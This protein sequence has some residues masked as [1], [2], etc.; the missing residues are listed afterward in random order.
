M[1]K[2]LLDYEDPDPLCFTYCAACYYYMGLYKDAEASA[3]QVWA[4]YMES[5]DYGVESRLC[6]V[7][8]HVCVVVAGTA[9]GLLVSGLGQPVKPRRGCISQRFGHMLPLFH[10]CCNNYRQHPSSM[11][12]PTDQQLGGN[13]VPQ[14][15]AASTCVLWPAWRLG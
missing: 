10:G 9:A 14:V 6:L 5:Y 7:Q 3:T 11:P 4:R 12:D 1:Y 15:A 2:E 13:G 8:S